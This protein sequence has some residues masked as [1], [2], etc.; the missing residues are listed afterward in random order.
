MADEKVAAK[1]LVRATAIG[2][3][4][5]AAGALLGNSA[6]KAKAGLIAALSATYVISTGMFLWIAWLGLWAYHLLT[7]SAFEPNQALRGYILIAIIIGLG[8]F[9]DQDNASNA[10]NIFPALKISLLQWA[11]LYLAS[12]VAGFGSITIPFLNAPIGLDIVPKLVL[13]FPIW[14]WYILLNTQGRREVRWMTTNMVLLY[15]FMLTTQYHIFDNLIPNSGIKVILANPTQQLR[16]LVDT[17][18]GGMQTGVSDFWR[19][20]T[21]DSIRNAVGEPQAQAVGPPVGVVLGRL[22]P[23]TYTADPSEIVVFTASV[24]DKDTW[25]NRQVTVNF[26]CEAVNGAKKRAGTADPSSVVLKKYL[27]FATVGCTYDTKE[28]SLGT[29]STKLTASYDFSTTVTMPIYLMQLELRDAYIESI[30]EKAAADQAAVGGATAAVQSSILDQLASQLGI[31]A[32]VA[33]NPNTPAIIGVEILP[34]Y[35]IGVDTALKQPAFSLKFNL[36]ANDRSIANWPGDVSKLYSMRLYLPDG[37]ELRP[38]S[39]KPFDGFGLGIAGAGAEYNSGTETKPTS[40][41]QGSLGVAGA[42]AEANMPNTNCPD[43]AGFQ[44]YTLRRTYV[45]AKDKKFPIFTCQV[46]PASGVEKLLGPTATPSSVSICANYEYSTSSSASLVVTAS[47]ASDASYVPGS[48][49]TATI[50]PTTADASMISGFFTNRC[51]GKCPCPQMA[52]TASCI[53]AVSKESGIPVEVLIGI[54]MKEGVCNANTIANDGICKDVEG[55]AIGNTYSMYGIIYVDTGKECRVSAAQSSDHVD[56]AFKGYATRCDA[57]KDFADLILHRGD[58]SSDPNDR[59]AT[60]RK[61]LN[62]PA[63]M[64]YEMQTA[65]Y[66]GS[67]TTWA[68]AVI[69]MVNSEYVAYVQGHQTA[70]AGVAT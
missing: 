3:A 48:T 14:P 63:K 2:V 69:A 18:I 67:S 17:G 35:I 28:M 57:V 32:P 70:S 13:L 54:P 39:C 47:G 37:F 45:A 30:R 41:Q 4:G 24:T 34:Y 49:G 19:F 9:R 1:A 22:D 15:F 44:S 36:Q 16:Q 38:G 65:K 26:N 61:Y 59:Y 46:Y 58:Y 5:G 23:K 50:K 8:L 10:R 6:S 40:F 20:I 68:D 21:V 53:A 25:E 66:A 31:T 11:I 7:L 27:D 51:S 52:D 62:D 42:G 43:V 55:R 33:K 56:G 60:A 12:L 29:W 64:L